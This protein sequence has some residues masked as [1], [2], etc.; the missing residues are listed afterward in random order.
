MIFL[1]FLDATLKKNL[2]SKKKREDELFFSTQYSCALK[3]FKSINKM[4][5]QSNMG[6]TSCQTQHIWVQP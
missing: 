3:R 5:A 6:L 2:K 1:P 4:L